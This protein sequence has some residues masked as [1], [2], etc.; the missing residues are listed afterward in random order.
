MSSGISL[1]GFEHWPT[2]GQIVHLSVTSFLCLQKTY[3]LSKICK[4]AFQPNS[5]KPNNLI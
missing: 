5:K 1:P 3:L 2:F 4:E